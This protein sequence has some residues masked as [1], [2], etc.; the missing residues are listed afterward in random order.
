MKEIKLYIRTLYIVFLFVKSERNNFIKINK[1][2]SPCLLGLVKALAKFV[3]ILEKVQA[4]D[5][6]SGFYWFALEFSQMFAEFPP[7]CESTEKVLYFL[8]EEFILWV[9]ALTSYTSMMAYGSYKII[10][11]TTLIDVTTRV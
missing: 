8:G 7:G 1:T 5:C 4:L 11:G 3:S 10:V 6:V 9:T 2:R